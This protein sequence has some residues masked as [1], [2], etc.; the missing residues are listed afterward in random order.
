M[1]HIRIIAPQGNLAVHE[2]FDLDFEDVNPIFNDNVTSGSYPV[3]L[4]VEKNR[5][6]L[7]NIDDI[8]SMLRSTDFEHTP[9]IIYIDGIPFRA[10][11]LVVTEGQQI[12]ESFDATIESQTTSL[13]DLIAELNCQ[14][15]PVDEDI[16]IGEMLGDLKV[17]YNLAAYV[18]ACVYGH[19]RS[20]LI[21]HSEWVDGERRFYCE[22]KW[23]DF[24]EDEQVS[25]VLPN[26]SA[27]QTTSVYEQKMP[28]VGFS[29]PYR[30]S[31]DS[32]SKERCFINT[33]RPYNETDEDGKPSR[34]CN[35]RVCYP[36]HPIGDDGTT[37]D[38]TT[39]FFTLD[40]TRPGSGICFYVLYFLKRLF[41]YLGF[42]YNEEKLCQIEDLRRLAFLTTHCQCETVRKKENTDEDT[43]P[44][45]T[46]IGQI[47][48]WLARVQETTQMRMAQFTTTTPNT[49]PKEIQQVYAATPI[50]GAI[51]GSTNV[52]IEVRETP[53][54]ARFSK[55]SL[56]HYNF[57][58]DHCDWGV[59][60]LTGVH[61]YDVDGPWY[62]YV[63]GTFNPSEETIETVKTCDL[64]P[65]R[66][67][68]Y[69]C[70]LVEGADADVA[71]RLFRQS[72][73][74]G[75]SLAPIFG[76][77][78]GTMMS[79]VKK[80]DATLFDYSVNASANIMKMM[81]NSKNFPDTSATNIIESMWASF[82]VRFIVSGEQKTV[83]AVLIRDVLRNQDAPIPIHGK[84][85]SITPVTEKT[86][87]VKMRYASE[88]N[89]S[90]QKKNIRDGIR[91]YNTSYNYLMEASTIDSNYTYDTIQHKGSTTDKTCYIDK[92][93]GNAYRFK[94]DKE[95]KEHFALFEVAQYKGIDIGDCS[96]ENEDYV[97]ELTSNFEPLIPTEVGGNTADTSV[98]AAFVDENMLN[99]NEPF[100]IQYQAGTNLTDNILTAE[101]HA[102]ESYDPSS[103]EEGDSPLQQHDWGTTVAIMR[104]GGADAT[105]QYF[106]Y[107]YD[108]QGNS[109][110]RTVSGH[111]A[112]TADCMDNFG[113]GYDYN[114]TQEGDGRG[115]RFSL[116]ITAYKHDEQG[117][118]L[119][120]EQ[121]NI[122]CNDDERDAA[123]NITRKIRS[124]G[125]Y[126][127]FMAEYAH[128][129]LHRKKYVI[130]MLCEIAELADIP[131]HWDSRYQIGNLVG[132]INKVNTHVSSE[133]GLDEVVIEFF[134]P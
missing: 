91:D 55:Q 47:N 68:V 57:E 128:F 134:T 120:D 39:G 94:V 37:S 90:E 4:P 112:L 52:P 58:T 67:T 61:I 38:E 75:T 93:T 3:N 42:D 6:F 56:D 73:A 32:Q 71:K 59:E 11:K 103:T 40:A 20:F 17:D 82:G 19:R 98:L 65:V 104:G 31:G 80:I 127:S 105:I 92:T 12:Q 16:Q 23:E 125:L 66:G 60:P 108:G 131:N 41:L 106:D 5:H 115:E 107:N 109:K 77:F 34:F 118:P 113:N 69:L 79:L 9:M 46:S 22:E 132:W 83:K 123:G 87:G 43:P 24:G 119:T 30:L 48:N 28:V 8:H 26:S 70:E 81:A 63:K 78:P 96:K 64:I 25:L 95:T 89:K 27:E 13:N 102:D 85:L 116:K 126:D 53:G 72:I 51:W 84:V 124:R 54:A 2:D 62:N 15:V 133:T 121:G 21:G 45:L 14:E 29:I 99:P 1:S 35:A 76:Q 117:N 114:G 130:R 50:H 111:Y 36:Y 86:T 33:T 129:L 97:I 88:E 18:N 100:E 44:D 74:A 110:Y 49:D 122:L 7:K 101:I 10:G